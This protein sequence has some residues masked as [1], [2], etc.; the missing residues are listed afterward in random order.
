M[1]VIPRGYHSEL[2]LYETQ[3]AIESIKH[4]FLAKL[5]AA[6]HLARV[7]APLVSSPRSPR[8]LAAASLATRTK[9]KPRSDTPLFT[10]TNQDSLRLSLI[11]GSI[12]CITLPVIS[13]KKS[14]SGK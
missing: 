6:L 5:C 7:T 9:R 1:T 14:I 11:C 4:I 8:R 12:R 2:S 13:T 10:A 3:K